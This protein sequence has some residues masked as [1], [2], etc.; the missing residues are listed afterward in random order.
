[1]VFHD[2][3][4]LQDVFVIAENKTRR[5]RTIKKYRMFARQRK[6]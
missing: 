4:R 6:A 1:M 3:R 5:E 2:D